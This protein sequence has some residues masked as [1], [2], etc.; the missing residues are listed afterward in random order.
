MM[1]FALI[2]FMALGAS[3]IGAPAAR[4]QRVSKV[5]GNRLLAMC[6]VKA[7]GECDAYLSGIADAIEAQGR[8]KAEACIPTPVTG[9]QLRDVAV[10][11]IR[12]NPQSRQMKA[13]ALTIKAFAAAFPCRS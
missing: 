11:Y 12:G 13:G 9:T 10:K 6:T 7:P 2:G 5:D 3:V 8:A 1:R 4:A